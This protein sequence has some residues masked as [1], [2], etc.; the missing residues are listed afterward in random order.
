MPGA[1][2]IFITCAIKEFSDGDITGQGIIDAQ[3]VNGFI[4]LDLIL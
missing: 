3:M 2:V 4:I 1:R